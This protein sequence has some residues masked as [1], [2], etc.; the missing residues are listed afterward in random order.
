[1][2]DYTALA[3]SPRLEAILNY[4]TL[5]A[6]EPSAVREDDL[7]IL[8][9]AGLSDEEILSVVLITCTFSFMTR[10]ADGLGVE[11]DD[12][13]QSNARTLVRGDSAKQTDHDSDWLHK[14]KAS[15]GAV[16]SGA[17]QPDAP[18]PDD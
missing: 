16:I 3:L 10:L 18:E 12:R 5:L 2:H 13:L 14:G 15:R 11:L 6:R 4:A 17:P 7:Q 1:M 8:R 9:Q